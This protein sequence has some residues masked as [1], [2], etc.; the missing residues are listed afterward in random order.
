MTRKINRSRTERRKK[1]RTEYLEEWKGKWPGMRKD[2]DDIKILDLIFKPYKVDMESFCGTQS[3]FQI[4][5]EE[6]YEN[7]G[8]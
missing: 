2:A 7:R 6:F 8:P 5:I 1:Y 3:E 4:A